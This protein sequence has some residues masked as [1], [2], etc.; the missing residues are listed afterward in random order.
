M[1]KGYGVIKMGNNFVIQKNIFDTF[2][3][4]PIFCFTSDIDWAPEWAIR[5]LLTEFK[6]YE[7]PISPFITHKSKIIDEYYDNDLMCSKVGVHPN[8]LPLSSHG[9][10]TLEVINFVTNLWPKS[11][12]F[13]SHCFFDNSSITNTF[14][15]KGF[16][17]DSNLCLFLHTYCTPLIHESSL[18]RFPVFWEDDVH[19]IKK[20]PFDLTVIKKYI[21]APGLKVFN[22]HPL[23]FSLN[24]PSIEYYKKY[25]FLYSYNMDFWNNKYMYKGKGIRTLIQILVDY[26]GTK[27][28]PTFYLN[29]IFLNITKNNFNL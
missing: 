12:S 20:L 15:N 25:K 1:N 2:T 19:C 6:K 16:K 23:S 9:T 4:N 22:I 13:R 7:I 27:N 14:F 10:T 18:L 17:Y 21:D 11:I 3:N 28:Y 8:F 29:D 26:I 24:M 5:D